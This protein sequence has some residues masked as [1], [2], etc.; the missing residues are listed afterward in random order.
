MGFTFSFLSRSPFNL[1][2]KERSTMVSIVSQDKKRL[3]L[4]TDMLQELERGFDV[5]SVFITSHGN[6]KNVEGV[7]V[8]SIRDMEGMESHKEFRESVAER[9][10]C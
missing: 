7:P 9:R 4:H 8:L 6:E 1:L 2:I 5:E 10:Y 3:S